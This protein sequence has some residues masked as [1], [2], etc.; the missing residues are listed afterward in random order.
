MTK[1]VGGKKPIRMVSDSAETNLLFH[2]YDAKRR[3]ENE[4]RQDRWKLAQSSA[5][6]RLPLNG[7]SR[8][9]RSPG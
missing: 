5:T 7:R 8:L 6:E 4:K 2:L 3:H 9:F 1:K